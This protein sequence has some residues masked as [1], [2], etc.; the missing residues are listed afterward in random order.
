MRRRANRLRVQNDRLEIP[1][2]KHYGAGDDLMSSTRQLPSVEI[3]VFGEEG[4]WSAV[5]SHTIKWWGLLIAWVGVFKYMGDEFLN[6]L[7]MWLGEVNFMDWRRWRIAEVIEDGPIMMNGVA[8][9][10]FYSSG[11]SF[12]CD[13]SILS[14]IVKRMNYTTKCHQKNHV[15]IFDHF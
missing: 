7:R 15:N 8:Y 4:G 1:Q 6:G 11:S 13:S 2:N 14:E 10:I 12:W 3:E 9:W 5:W